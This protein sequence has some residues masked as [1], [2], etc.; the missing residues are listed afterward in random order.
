VT[1]WVGTSGYQ[2]PEWRGSFYP[3]RYPESQMLAFYTRHFDTVEINYTSYQFPTEKSIAGWLS[4]APDGFKY[5]PKVPR[6]VTYGPAALK[7]AGPMQMFLSRINGLGDKLGPV[8]MQL[9][10]GFAR[11]DTVLDALVSAVPSGTNMHIELRDPSWH[12]DQVFET[13]RAHGVGLCISDSEELVTPVVYT[14]DVAYFRLRH[15]G[16]QPADLERWAEAVRSRHA[17]S[18]HDVFAYFKHEGTGSGPRFAREL[19]RL[20]GLPLA[21]G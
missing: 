7:A 17:E 11:D 6:K 19:K 20:L 16:Y 10:P 12:H 15:E 13:L 14:S 18:G 4:G 21:D 9:P 1:I 8:L 3:E 2:Y 5:A